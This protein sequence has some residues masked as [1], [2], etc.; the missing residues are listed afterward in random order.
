M[1]EQDNDPIEADLLDQLHRNRSLLD[2]HAMK[3]IWYLEQSPDG[4]FEDP[5][6]QRRPQNRN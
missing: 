1:D 2:A 6:Y 3:P 5:E 4:I